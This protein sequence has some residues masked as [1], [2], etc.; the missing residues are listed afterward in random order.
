MNT[1]AEIRARLAAQENKQSNNFDKT[2]YQFWNMETGKTAVVRFLPDGDSS[3]DFFWIEKLSIKLPFAGIKGT[4]ET[5]QVTVT[6][7][8]VEMF[9]KAEYPSGCPI[10]AQVRGWYKDV[11]MTEQ[12]N[13]YWKK[14][15]YILQGFVRDNPIADDVAN[16]PENPI[17]RFVLNTQLFNTIKSALLNPD[18]EHL[19]T[20]YVSGTDFRITKTLKGVYADYSTSGYARKDTALTENELAAIEKYGLANLAD[21]LPKKPTALELK[22][23]EEMFEAS[24]NGEQ[25]DPTRWAAYYKPFGYN[26]SNDASG[27][28]EKSENPAAPEVKAE[29]PK[30][31]P[32][33]Q[34]KANGGSK[35][36][37]ILAAIQNRNK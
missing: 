20:E 24:V 37:E 32:K 22:V 21:S 29:T 7:P 19:P 35:A 6:V 17:R 36:A 2:S 23:L 9:P 31:E 14:R 33:L 15:S 25:Y 27:K 1:L 13:K 5:K 34:V 16:A 18:M 10:L 8:C 26:D 12:A 3:N 30:E 28:T 11:S 4:S